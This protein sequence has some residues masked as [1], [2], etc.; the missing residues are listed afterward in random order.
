V[1]DGVGA[2]V[3]VGDGEGVGAGVG[4][5]VGAGVGEGV[6]A[7]VGV[8]LGVGLGVGRAVGL[9]VGLSGRDVGA[10]VGVAAGA[11]VGAAAVGVADAVEESSVGSGSPKSASGGVGAD[12]GVDVGAGSRPAAREAKGWSTNTE[13]NAAMTAHEMA[14]AIKR[15]GPNAASRARNNLS[16]P[17]GSGGSQIGNDAPPLG[18]SLKAISGQHCAPFGGLCRGASAPRCQPWCGS[19][20][21]EPG[22]EIALVG[23]SEE[24]FAGMGQPAFDE[25]VR[26]VARQVAQSEV[27]VVHFDLTPPR[28]HDGTGGNLFA[29]DRPG[30]A[31]PRAGREGGKS[32]LD[33]GVRTQDVRHQLDRRARRPRSDVVFPSGGAARVLVD[34][35]T[36][37]RALEAADHAVRVA[38]DVGEHMADGPPREP[39]GLTGGG[40]GETRDRGCESRMSAGHARDVDRRWCLGVHARRVSGGWL[41]VTTWRA[42]V[43][44]TPDRP[45]QPGRPNVC[46]I[47]EEIRIPVTTSSTCARR[48]EPNPLYTHQIVRPMSLLPEHPFATIFP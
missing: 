31:L 6:G 16:R 18:F 13:T 41:V 14:A 44:R 22:E 17:D 5:G 38:R 8:G 9:G 23:G 47:P 36:G 19:A 28:E 10:W 11:A 33:G 27:D 15:L 39:A 43:I 25:V 45:S 21:H 2:G 46:P 35:L 20:P 30:Q 4:E 3:S 29:S 24:L 7:G 37:R 42:R 34:H 12:V 1:G 48:A 40:V 26:P 32:R